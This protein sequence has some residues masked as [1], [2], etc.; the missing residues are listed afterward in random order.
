MEDICKNRNAITM[1]LWK[2]APSAWRSI[3]TT[4]KEGRKDGKPIGVFLKTANK[5]PTVV[6]VCCYS[7]SPLEGGKL[8]ESTFQWLRIYRLTQKVIYT[9]KLFLDRNFQRIFRSGL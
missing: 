5:Q 9:L 6:C 4:R 1:Y 2:M 3:C 7:K 8:L